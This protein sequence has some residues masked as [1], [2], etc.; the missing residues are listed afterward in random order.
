MQQPKTILYEKSKEALKAVLPIAGIVLVLS[1]AA[2]PVPTTTMLAFFFGAILVIA[3]M[4]FFS[5]GAELAMEPMGETMGS[6]VTR[7]RRLLFILPLGFFLGLMITISEPDLTVLANQVQ[8]I[9]NP[10]LIF[11]VAAGVGLFLAAALLRMV[12]AVPLHYMLLVCYL[13]VFLLAAIAPDAFLSV[14]FDAG[15]VTT[16]P[17][18]VPFIMAFGIGASAIRND[19]NAAKDSFGLIALCSVGPVLAVLLLG[20]L[21]HPADAAYV[22]QE[23]LSVADSLEMGRVFASAFPE[24]AKEVLGAILPI[25]LFFA[26]FQFAALHLKKRTLLRIGSGI[27]YTFFG[28]V[29]FLLGGNVGFLPMGMMLGSLLA[30]APAKGLLVPAGML[31]GFF[32]VRA[33]PAVYV[34]MKQVEEITDGA[35]AGNTLKN[36]LSVGVAVSVGI[37]MIRVLTGLPI[38]WILIPGYGAA[39]ILSFFV[40]HMFTGIA[41]DSGGVA[42]GPVTA[43]F[44]LP[45]PMGAC[46]ALGG[47]VVRDAFGVVA[48]VAMTPLVTIQCLGLMYARGRKKRS[49]GGFAPAP[50]ADDLYVIID[51]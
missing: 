38:L 22:M 23:P 47:N 11:S 39:L 9:P 30:S 44:L 26:V 7:T 46:T 33:E 1:L 31:M 29:L 41:F 35:I 34:L 13:L 36:A 14:A 51:L 6:R 16:G 10:V 32:I 50:A 40:P 4:I 24:Y 2:A 3:G 37:A 21:Y 20:I 42:S 18:T 27:V 28:L 43:S 48:M 49:A 19:R 17:M 5:V 25:T 15:G 45:M 8:T 12:F